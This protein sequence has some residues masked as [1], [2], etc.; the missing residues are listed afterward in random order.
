[1][2]RRCGGGAAAERR[3]TEY[4][5]AHTGSTTTPRSC[6]LAPSSS[7]FTCQSRTQEPEH[8][9]RWANGQ[10]RVQRG[11]GGAQL[12]ALAARGAACLLYARERG[13]P[14]LGRRRHSPPVGGLKH[15]AAT[16]ARPLGCPA[17][18]IG[19]SGASTGTT[20]S[21]TT[22]TTGR[23]RRRRRRLC[24]RLAADEAGEVVLRLL[25]RQRGQPLL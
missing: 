13:P 21:T 22:T 23:R 18:T 11:G 20:T 16:G 24:V 4:S 9:R 19:G 3:G 1:M 25:L 15:R 6:S 8:G 14:G 7:A 17:A 5:T 10:R 12:D 2:R